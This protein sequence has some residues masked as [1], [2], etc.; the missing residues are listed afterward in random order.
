[1]EDRRRAV[2]Q[3]APWTGQCHIQDEPSDLWRECAIIDVSAFGL[4]IDL[5]HPD[6][7]ELL[8]MWQDGELRLDVSRRV[9]VR[10]ELGPSVDL[11]VA[12]EVRNAG[13][14]PDGIVRAGIE[15]VD[16][17]E[18]ERSL[19]EFLGHRAL[20]RFPQPELVRFVSDD[21]AMARL[22]QGRFGE[23]APDRIGDQPASGLPPVFE[24]VT[25]SV[26]FVTNGVVLAGATRGVDLV[27]RPVCKMVG[28]CHAVL[29]RSWQEARRLA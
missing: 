18:D 13:S 22:A 29:R 23:G 19:V 14:A 4:G 2:R 17:T 28:T 9:T 26:F 8:G 20:P 16:L 27:G 24:L 25:K 1:V 6:P 11:T 12:G 7:V 3:S 5:C 10:L 21:D 15:F